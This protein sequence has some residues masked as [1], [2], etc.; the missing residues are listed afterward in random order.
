M[1]VKSIKPIK[2]VTISGTGSVMVSII[3]TVLIS[4]AIAMIVAMIISWDC[5]IGPAIRISIP[6]IHSP[7][8]GAGIIMAVDT[9]ANLNR[10]TSCA[11]F[12]NCQEHRSQN[13]GME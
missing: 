1:P 12:R 2:S 6:L 11:D 8:V 7:V 3:K 10:E 4:M 13:K 9:W 5:V